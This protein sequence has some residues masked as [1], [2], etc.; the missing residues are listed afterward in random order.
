MR[1]ACVLHEH[2]DARDVWIAPGLLEAA[3][4]SEGRHAAAVAEFEVLTDVVDVGELP[5]CSGRRRGPHQR[6]GPVA[7]RHRVAAG[8]IA[9]IGPKSGRSHPAGWREE[10]YRQDELLR[11]PPARTG[12]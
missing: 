6:G 5:Q 7:S 2:P 11:V 12:G 8:T 9:R 4:G 3:A 10:G 1:T